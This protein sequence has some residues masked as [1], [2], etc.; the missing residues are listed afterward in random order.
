MDAL[1]NVERKIVFW[2]YTAGWIQ[3]ADDDNDRTKPFF[4]NLYIVL[5]RLECA[6]WSFWC[7]LRFTSS[8]QPHKNEETSDTELVLYL[9]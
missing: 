3:K 6:I 4:L 9:H 5:Q 7:E 1:N 2:N 8:L